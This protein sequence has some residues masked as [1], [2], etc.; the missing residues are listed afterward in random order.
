[1]FKKAS[2]EKLDDSTDI[3][4]VDVA[5][6]KH[7]VAVDDASNEVHVEEESR[8]EGMLMKVVDDEVAAAAT[9]VATEEEPIAEHVCV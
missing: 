7:D 3:A 4:P 8:E 1:M 2:S 9:A 6:A 5:V